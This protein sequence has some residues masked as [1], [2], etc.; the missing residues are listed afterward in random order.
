MSAAQLPE[1][2]PIHS[3]SVKFKS[4]W[5]LAQ[6]CILL[7]FNMKILPQIDLYNYTHSLTLD[8]WGST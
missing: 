8:M 4:D 3:N 1:E 6:N 7:L 5:P 2:F